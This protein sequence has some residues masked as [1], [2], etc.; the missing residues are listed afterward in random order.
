MRRT[1]NAVLNTNVVVEEVDNESRRKALA[2]AKAIAHLLDSSIAVP[3]TSFRIG[4]DPLLGL[5]PGI[6]DVVSL[7]LSIPTV[8]IAIRYGGSWWSIGRMVANLGIDA[9]VGAIPILGNLFD[10]GFKANTRNL[11]I[12]TAILQ[13][14]S[15]RRTPQQMVRSLLTLTIAMILI[16]AATLVL[17]LYGVSRLLVTFF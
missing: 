4:L 7:G 1:R 3:G 5:V 11:H 13:G 15:V 14:S 12:L 8:F 9:M 10:F 17:A 6:G 16:I 2:S